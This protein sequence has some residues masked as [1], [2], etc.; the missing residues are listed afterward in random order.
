MLQVFHEHFC[1]SFLI[2]KS[3]LLS[4]LQT[5]C[6]FTVKLEQNLYTV[7]T[8]TKMLMLSGVFWRSS[9][10]SACLQDYHQHQTNSATVLFSQVLKTFRDR[11]STSSL[12]TLL[13]YCTTLQREKI[14]PN[15]CSNL[16][17]H[18]LMLWPLF[19]TRN[20]AEGFGFIISLACLQAVAGY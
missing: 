18:K 19:A 16:Q 2:K 17:S 4:C 12:G 13:Q 10:P 3:P 8:I 11:Y 9:S 7:H 6:Y 15:F 14:I 5:I 1:L 20:Y